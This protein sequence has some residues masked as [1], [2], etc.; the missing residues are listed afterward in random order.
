M[1]AQDIQTVLNKVDY[2]SGNN[3]QEKLYLHIDKYAYT[4]G[5]TIWFKA[6]TTIGIQN[7]FSRL[8]NIGYV[9]LIDPLNRIVSSIKI[10]I[11]NGIGIGDLP[12]ID[13]LTAGSYRLRA[14]TNW[15]RNDDDRY[16]FDRTIQISNGRADNVLTATSVSQTDDGEA[17][18]IALKSLSG[19]PLSKTTVYYELVKDGETLRKKR[20]STDEQGILTIDVDNKF[21]G[22]LIK[23][24]F[25][26][27]E[28]MPVNKIIRPANPRS[29]NSVQLF[30][31]G[32][33]ILIG[34]LNN[35]AVKSINPQGLAV[36]SKVFIKS[37][38]DT[39]SIIETNDLGMGASY[40]FVGQDTSLSATAVFADGSTTDVV[41]PEIVSEGYSIIL[42][43]RNKERIISQ[44][45]LSQNLVN[46]EDLYFIAHHMGQVYYVSKQKANKNELAFSV[47]RSTLPTGVITISILNSQFMP[48][49]ERAVFNYADESRLPLM[50]TLNKQTYGR[51]DSVR[52]HVLA[53]ADRDSIRVAA[54]SASVINLNKIQDDYKTAP[55]ILSSLL[56]SADING[57]IEKP[58]YYFAEG[59]IKDQELDYLMLT[60]GWRNIDWSSI[61]LEIKPKFEAEK[62]VKIAGYTKKLGRKAPEPNATVQLISTK[63]F[64]DF[65][66]TVSNEEGYFDFGYLLFPDSIKFL[67]SARTK[68][69]KKNIDIIVESN[70][71]PAVTANRNAPL[72]IND[73][74]TVF[75]DQIKQSKQFFAQ[76][77]RTGLMEKSIAIE[78]VVVRATAR[79]E[80]SENSSNLNGPGN[81]DQVL[82][83]EDLSTCTTLEMCLA[84]RIMGV[85][86]VDGAPYNTRG[87]V[88]MQVVLDGMFIEPEEISMINVM[89]I[90][91]VEVLRNSNYT[92]IYG[93]NGGNGLLILT[94]KSGLSA[95]SNYVPRG[96]LTI[97]PQGLYA[98]RTF[99]KPEYDVDNAVKL[100]RDLRTTIHWEPA[101]VSDM[102]GKTAFSFFTADEPGKYLIT[103]EG[104][105]LNGR[106]GRKLVTFEVK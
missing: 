85:R 39:L 41:L 87:N 68:K 8:S 75:L 91:S 35:V 59:K 74:N 30:A 102:S 67:V 93:M 27:L 26:N 32:G 71:P 65:I 7:L 52:V 1:A 90:E 77:E 31:E 12:L 14:Y 2:T 61:G 34:S 79:K 46:H 21:A 20:T 5:E 3:P 29:K 97:Q 99:Y 9:E 89:D 48:V 53:G 43:T 24:R 36:K 72:E 57:F 15:M 63:N 25:D 101:I 70:E 4:A 62:G 44:V 98:T 28:K 55:D 10:P 92:G 6:Y 78:E 80:V 47:N 76:L 58:G 38:T 83:A 40:I 16:F 103:L 42:N 96:I 84:G 86:W 69:G 100:A 22:T 66:D 105:D 94:S 11:L 104:V 60:Q 17:Y 51:R 13:T 88:P 73:V 95:R 81:A 19:V 64:M 49:V 18:T 106:I 54:L 50:A 23:L 56:L 37:R 45:N 33:K 82:T